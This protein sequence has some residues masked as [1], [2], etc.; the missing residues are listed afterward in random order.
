MFS[1]DAKLHCNLLPWH[2]K[3]RCGQLWVGRATSI[4]VDSIVLPVEVTL[5]NWTQTHG[6]PCLLL[7]SVANIQGG[8]D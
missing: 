7:P 6:S 5:T 4:T 8:P 1:R 2:K 3:G